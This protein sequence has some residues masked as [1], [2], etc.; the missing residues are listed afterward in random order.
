MLDQ[1]VDGIRVLV[2]ARAS[3]VVADASAEK[4]AAALV[5]ATPRVHYEP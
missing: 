5:R 3:G 2:G 4:G 1:A